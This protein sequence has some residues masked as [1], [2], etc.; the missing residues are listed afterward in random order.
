MI[1]KKHPLD[2]IRGGTRSSE[3]IMRKQKISHGA[4]GPAGA[5]DVRGGVP[6]LVRGA[7]RA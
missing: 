1:P 6:V 4:T 2:L 3:T 7:A 5:P